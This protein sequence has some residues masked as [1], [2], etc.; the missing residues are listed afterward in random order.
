MARSFSPADAKRVLER[1]Q[2]IF[3]KLNGAEA[4]VEKYRESVKKASEA[5]VMQEVLKVLRD[6]PIEEINR[7]KKGFRVK[8][9]REHGYRTI[10]YISPA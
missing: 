7:D 3:E 5:L 4:Y 1:H 10:S 6:I 8:A 2:S 9:L